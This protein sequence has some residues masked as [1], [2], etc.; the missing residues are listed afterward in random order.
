MKRIFLPAGTI[1]VIMKEWIWVTKFIV[2][3]NIGRK[4]EERGGSHLQE[5]SA[6]LYSPK[7]TT[8]GD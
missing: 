8:A 7:E 5:V 3:L 2:C 1:P 6:C 4:A